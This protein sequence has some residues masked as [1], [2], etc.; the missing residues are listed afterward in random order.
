VSYLHPVRPHFAGRF[1][2]DVSTVN[3]NREHFDTSTFTPIFQRPR[4]CGGDGSNWQPAGTGS[5]RLLDV[6]VTRHT[7]LEGGAATNLADDVAV[8]LTVREAGDR[9]SAKIVDL[10]TDQQGVSMLYG[11]GI[12]LVDA[13]G[14]EF[15]RGEFEPAAFF[16]LHF[17]RSSGG[18]D[19]GAA[20]YFQSVLTDVAWSDLSASPCLQQLQ[21]ASEPG[22]LSIRFTTD[23]YSMREPTRGYGRI[24]G[25]IGPYLAGEP[26]TFVF[27]RHLQVDKGGTGVQADC[28]VDTARRKVLL[29]VG[30]VL[31]V[32][33]NGDFDDLGELTLVAGNGASAPSL[34]AI[35]YQGP[36][37]YRMTAGVFELPQGRELTDGELTAATQQPL[38]LML[39]PPG[40]ATPTRMGAEHDDGIYVR[41]ERF[42]F[43]LD[44]GQHDHTDLFVTRFGVPLANA[45][46]V[47]ATVP[48]ASNNERLPLPHVAVAERTDAAGRAR[49]TVTGVDPNK[50]RGFIDGQVYAIACWVEVPQSEPD[51]SV[52]LNVDNN[53]I[54][55]L[56]FD[57][58]TELAEPGWADVAPILMQYSN[59]YPRPHGPDPYMPFADFPSSHP[60]SRTSTT[61][62]GSPGASPRRCRSRSP[63]PT[64]CR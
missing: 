31:S 57:A 37:T 9:A 25:T 38:R 46:P 23:M 41:P 24:A 4:C 35:A 1:R 42:V 19:A 33:G 39:R 12:V 2:A 16:N 64:T 8:G 49:L 63:I 34:G 51:F 29:D 7:R 10:D 11:L 15:M 21:Q 40:G 36:G 48:L 27:G 20:S 45:K 5:W 32:D 62:G 47:S 50:P 56:V 17:A 30:H 58:V 18:G 43:R 54:S 14:T 55:V 28:V 53:F 13:Q 6:A 26:R 52:L 22:L 60:T 3:N 59:L 61:S 44:P